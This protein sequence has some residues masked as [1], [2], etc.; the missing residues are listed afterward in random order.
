MNGGLVCLL[1]LRSCLGVTTILVAERGIG[2]ALQ[3]PYLAIFRQI[4]TEKLFHVTAR[5][6][7][8]GIRIVLRTVKQTCLE[9]FVLCSAGYSARFGGNVY[10]LR[11]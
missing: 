8:S 11:S 3:F 10:Y 9:S 7:E 6:E 1:E 5:N 2:L 4:G